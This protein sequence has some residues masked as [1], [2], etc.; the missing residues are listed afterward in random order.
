M[1]EELDDEF[2]LQLKHDFLAEAS[3]LLFKF[4]SILL[5]INAQKHLSLDEIRDIFKI[6]RKYSGPCK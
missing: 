3:D 4:D 5:Q 6:I 2:I 1:N